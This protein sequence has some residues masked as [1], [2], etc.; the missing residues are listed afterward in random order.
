MHRDL[1]SDNIFLM[2]N[3]TL[4]LGDLGVSKITKM[5]LAHTQTGIPYYCVP[6]I[7]REKTYND[8]CDIWTLDC[9]IY[10]ICSL[11]LPFKGNSIEKYIV[12]FLV[13]NILLFLI[14]ILRS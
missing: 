4:K 10:E 14:F 7:W 2:K 12:I 6:E 9:I 5:G 3:G 1:K 11:K 13:E 8:K